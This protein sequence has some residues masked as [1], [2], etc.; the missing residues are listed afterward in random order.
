M[1]QTESIIGNSAALANALEQVSHLAQINR[2]I[3]ILGE[4]GTGKELAAQLQS[5]PRPQ[6]DASD[7]A[8]QSSSRRG[9]S[10]VLASINFTAFSHPTRQGV[11]WPQL[12]SS[13]NLNILRAAALVLS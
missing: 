2:P 1:R 13:K 5:Y 3:L 7:I 4:R 12:S 11:H 8:V 9:W 6:I 10:Q